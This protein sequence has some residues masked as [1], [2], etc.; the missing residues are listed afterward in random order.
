VR[1]VKTDRWAIAVNTSSEVVKDLSFNIASTAGATVWGQWSASSVISRRGPVPGK[2]LVPYESIFRHLQS[3]YCIPVPGALHP[4][5]IEG[6][7][8]TIFVRR[9]ALRPPIGYFGKAKFTISGHP[10]ALQRFRV[11]VRNIRRDWWVVEELEDAQ[12]LPAA[13]LGA[14]ES[15]DIEDSEGSDSEDNPDSPDEE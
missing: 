6:A 4:T 9:I 3:F 12:S 10:T 5:G 2:F 15:A 13:A 14:S 11:T 8:Q 7:N 1:T